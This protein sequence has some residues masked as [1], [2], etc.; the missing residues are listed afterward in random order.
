MDH[1]NC[2]FPFLSTL[3]SPCESNSNE[4]DVVQVHLPKY[5]PH[6]LPIHS[7][8]PSELREK[9]LPTC[10]PTF[11]VTRNDLPT[12][13]YCM[14]PQTLSIRNQILGEGQSELPYS[15]TPPS[16]TQ[17]IKQG[18]D[19]GISNTSADT[20]SLSDV[21][22]SNAFVPQGSNIVRKGST[23]LEPKQLDY[24]RL[25]APVLTSAAQEEANTLCYVNAKFKWN[26]QAQPSVLS[27]SS[28][29]SITSS[30]ETSSNEVYRSEPIGDSSES[31]SGTSVQDRKNDEIELTAFRTLLNRM[32]ALKFRYSKGGTK[33]NTNLGLRIRIMKLLSLFHVITLVTFALSIVTNNKETID[34]LRLPLE[35]LLIYLYA[36]SIIFIL[37]VS[38]NHLLISHGLI[39]EGCV[40]V[41]LR[42]QQ[43]SE[44]Q[45]SAIQPNVS[46]SFS[47]SC[48][49]LHV[50]R[51]RRDYYGSRRQSNDCMTISHNTD[52]MNN[53][54]NLISSQACPKEPDEVRRKGRKQFLFHLTCVREFRSCL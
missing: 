53:P 27:S 8:I 34:V 13:N 48:G 43:N 17:P 46:R 40:S 19:S 22:Q 41:Q 24:P 39:D 32:P 37:L 33:K 15:S 49:K 47:S 30:I 36:G 11:E 16:A 14:I 44:L 10:R 6:P 51:D 9:L 3:F 28:K 4:T 50:Q 25:Y 7:P 2:N 23:I 26:K 1:F 35:A 54:E 21:G 38:I 18:V 52:V 45:T 20:F 5:R 12:G 31:G 42:S 29:T